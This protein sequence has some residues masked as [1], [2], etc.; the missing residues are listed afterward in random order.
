MNPTTRKVECTIPVLSVRD[1]HKNIRF[2]T[3]SLGFNVDWG[4]AAGSVI[5]SV[6]RD[7]CSIMLCQVEN[8]AWPVWVWIG[9]EDSSLFDEL[10]S[11]GVRVLQPPQNHALGLRNEVRRYRWQRALAWQ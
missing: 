1:L 9:L 7:G 6:S 2:Y 5:C 3:E 8:K 11:K 10:S 4:G